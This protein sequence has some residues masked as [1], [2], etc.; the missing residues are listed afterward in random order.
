MVTALPL[1]SPVHT[2]QEAPSSTCRDNY[3]Y[4]TYLHFASVFAK[5]TGLTAPNLEP[6]PSHELPSFEVTVDEVYTL[7]KSIHLRLQAPMVFCLSYV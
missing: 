1:K 6:S 7:L 2:L 5:D 3:G 4:P